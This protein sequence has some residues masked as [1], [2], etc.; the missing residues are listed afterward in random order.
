MLTVSDDG[1]H[2][3]LLCGCSTCPERDLA[4]LLA[5]SEAQSGLRGTKKVLYTPSGL[6]LLKMD[7]SL[8]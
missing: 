1:L 2:P 5:A 4:H 7:N 8:A 3:R 6:R